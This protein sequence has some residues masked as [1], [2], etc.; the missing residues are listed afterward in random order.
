MNIIT[1]KAKHMVAA[2]ELA[3]MNYKEEQT[4]VDAL[5]ELIDIPDLSIFVKNGLGVAAFEG[6][7]LVG[8]IG[9]YSPWD[10]AFDTK[11]RGTFTPVHAHGCIAE[12]RARIYSLM[13]QKMAKNL[14]QSRCCIM[15]LLYM[16]MI[17]RRLSHI[18]I[19]ALGI[20]VQM[21]L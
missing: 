5:P 11:A 14:L 18:F 17:Q 21:P 8:F 7:E 19:M 16:S 13:Y 10:N 3:L 1:L 20:V 4:V 12:N 6:E 15:G 9:C 2:R